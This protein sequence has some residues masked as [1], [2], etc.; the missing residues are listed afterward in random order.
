MFIFDAPIELSQG[1]CRLKRCHILCF[2]QGPRILRS[3]P[4]ARKLFD[5]KLLKNRREFM[6]S[7]Q[8]FGVRAALAPIE[9]IGHFARSVSVT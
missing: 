8:L 4:R 1:P 7:W 5:S 2:P 3:R 9:K 6:G